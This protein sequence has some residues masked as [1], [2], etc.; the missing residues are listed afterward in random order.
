MGYGL[1]GAAVTKLSRTAT[2]R[3]MHEPSGTPRLPRAARR[4][5]SFGMMLLFAA[6]AGAVLAFGDV[7]QEQR[8]RATARATR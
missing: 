2:R 7:L 5:K 3:A 6:L 1:V 4:G 8:N